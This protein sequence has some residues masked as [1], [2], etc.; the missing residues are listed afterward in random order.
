MAMNTMNVPLSQTSIDAVITQL[1]LCDALRF[2]AHHP[3]A[4]VV[5]VH[6]CA[7]LCQDCMCSMSMAHTCSE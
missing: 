3:L 6:V 2:C 4:V 1:T 7:Y 5:V